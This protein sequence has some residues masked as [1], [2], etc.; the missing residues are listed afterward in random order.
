MA[1][2]K[3]GIR[4]SEDMDPLLRELRGRPRIRRE[5]LEAIHLF[6]KAHTIMLAEEKI[7][8]EDYAKKILI[9]LREIE[10]K[11]VV[12]ARLE[13]GEGIHSGE[14]YLTKR[15]GEE[16]GGW[17]HIGRSS[18]D[19]QCV[20]HRIAVRRKITKLM[21]HLVELQNAILT[22]AEKHT[23][24]IMPYYT[25]WQQAQSTTLAHYLLSWYYPL[26]RHFQRCVDLLK[27]V[28][29]NPAGAA[30]GTGSD[31]PLNRKRTEELLGFEST[32]NNTM[33]AEENQDYMLESFALLALV[34]DTLTLV[35]NRM[36]IWNTQEFSYIELAD[37]WC[38]TSSIM[39]QKKN[40]Y[41]IE[42]ILRMAPWIT[43]K[44]MGGL[45]SGGEQL[46]TLIP[47]FL[48]AADDLVEIIGLLTGMLNTLKVNPEIMT[49]RC[50]ESWTQAADLAAAISRKRGLPFRTAHQ[51]V[52]ILTRK[53]I[54]TGVL[55]MNVT[56]EMVDE[57]SVHYT[58]RPIHF[59]QSEL[60]EAI[61]PMRSIE[62]RRGQ[63][64][65]APVAVAD[66]IA[67]A[68]NTLTKENDA[69]NELKRK[70]EKILQKLDAAAGAILSGNPSLPEGKLVRTCSSRRE[71]K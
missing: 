33:D 39:P 24:T 59:T 8:N 50:Q 63:G 67:D 20:A 26:E 37:R 69:V 22:L 71:G 32:Y 23:K 42:Q 27:R 17:I 18:G 4:L 29:I 40:P 48:E 65:P 62:R 15:F 16:T 47:H 9:G 49:Q 31:Y 44:L 30:I 21:G 13:A 34:T 64:E 36:Y 51:I 10:S 14:A 57:A 58:G 61:D 28:N 45:L 7:L 6:D 55:P 38:G 53:A 52:G 66:V 56:P 1:Y 12:E 2:R 46:I 35:A 60:K 41:G 70:E 68:H 11:G 54:E 3:P 25:H 5:V 43:S 19:L